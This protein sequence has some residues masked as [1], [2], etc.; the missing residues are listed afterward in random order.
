MLQ[1][2]FLAV[3][4]LG[5]GDQSHEYQEQA[6]I[7]QAIECSRSK[8]DVHSHVVNKVLCV[9]FPSKLKNLAA[10]AAKLTCL[11]EMKATS[12]SSSPAAKDPGSV[13]PK[14]NQPVARPIQQPHTSC[15]T[16]ELTPAFL[17]HRHWKS[18][19]Q[20]SHSEGPVM[21]MDKSEVFPTE[22]LAHGKKCF[23]PCWSRMH[24]S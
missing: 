15:T 10:G 14:R 13:L 3:G 16:E 6:F 23:L 22:L 2:S 19:N 18:T 11:L 24:L 12:Q 8:D 20:T 9:K 7:S 5:E 4:C 21:V 17:I 1:L